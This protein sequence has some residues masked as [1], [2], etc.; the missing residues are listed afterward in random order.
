MARIVRL[1]L[2]FL[3]FLSHVTSGAS[4]LS[5]LKQRTQLLKSQKTQL[6]SQL[7]TSAIAKEH[8]Q[9][10][11]KQKL[12]TFKIRRDSFTSSLEL[13]Q[14][15]M[16]TLLQQQKQWNSQLS[17][18]ASKIPFDSL[19][20]KIKY[21]TQ[22][23]TL[24]QLEL[25]YLT[26][27]I[28]LLN[29]L[30][31]RNVEIAKI[32]KIDNLRQLRK[33]ES[34]KLHDEIKNLRQ[35]NQ[36][37]LQQ[38][39][40]EDN[41]LNP[42][43][44]S[45]FLNQANQII[46]NI[47]LSLNSLEIELLQLNIKLN[48]S[49]YLRL[50]SDALIT[51]DQL[52]VRLQ[53]MKL[54]IDSANKIFT[55]ILV[56]KKNISDYLVSKK[57][58]EHVEIKQ[59]ALLKQVLN[60]QQKQIKMLTKQFK[61]LEHDVNNHLIEY[62]EERERLLKSRKGLLKD[63]LSQ[64]K[65]LITEF[66]KL[67][68]AGSVYVYGI[69]A[70]VK[71]FIKAL[72]S[73]EQLTTFLVFTFM[74]GVWFIIKRQLNMIIVKAHEIDAQHRVLSVLRGILSRNWNGLCLIL[75]LF[76]VF[77]AAKIP[78]ASYQL[79]FVIFAVWFVFRI[80]INITRL[81]LLET[82]S[83]VAGL[84]VR[85]YHRLKLTF[86]VGGIITVGT[87]ISH[88]LHMHYLVTEFFD[89]LFMIFL[90][91]VSIVLLRGHSVLLTLLH[92]Y[93]KPNK[94]YTKRA[95]DLFTILVPLSLLVNGALGI[96][97]YVQFA[98]SMS[99]YQAIIVIV[100]ISYVVL[101]GILLDAL[102]FISKTMI[103]KLNNGWL[104]NEALLKP[105]HKILL[106]L[107]MIFLA[108]VV[109]RLYGLDSNTSVVNF[110]LDVWQ[111]NIFNVSR[112]SITTKSLVE[113]FILVALLIWLSKW[114]R[115]FCY[116][117]LFNNVIDPG[118][119]NSLSIFSQYAMMAIG[120]IITLTVLGIDISGISM[121]LGG[122]AVGMGF[123]LRDFANNIVGGLVMLIERP[124]KEGDLISV[125]NI[126]GRVIHIG[127]RSM[128]IRSWDNYEVVLPNADTFIK[129][130]TNWT[131]KDSVVRTV[132]A[133]KVNRHDSPL[134]VQQLI[135]D[136]LKIM[137]E[138]LDNPSSQVFLKH[139]D[140]ALIELEVRYYINVEQHSRV[141]VRSNVLFA[142]MAQFKAAGIKAPIPPIQIS[143]DEN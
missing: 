141:E 22:L 124:V 76:I 99:Y 32:K 66:A 136:V 121:I 132:V 78:P 52:I 36:L 129:P 42:S 21:I 102:E 79:V 62:A 63:S 8:D 29:T 44:I 72:S 135:L 23:I 93:L 96:I 11:I 128:I 5:I 125:A 40:D 10:E 122:L 127:L 120:A 103:S 118:L 33:N 84:D 26:R 4:S 112:I 140:D 31:D 65:K 88:Y 86:I 19:K 15:E 25:Q 47:S 138:V 114:S 59:K 119:R 81:A 97:G 38:Q 90:F 75:L 70:R 107:T 64:G 30:I 7:N 16:Q 116:R 87:V 68:Q 9:N 89:R 100:V 17:S 92:S 71:D 24:K 133:I 55:T 50:R 139:I 126:E 69:Y 80:T 110:L 143:T 131:H 48:Y 134:K 94:F 18:T 113:F 73:I 77:N 39:L 83:D 1:F 85:L 56:E 12:K 108:M 34:L 13:S 91:T 41:N 51:L 20:S 106:Y 2:L 53:N 105:L 58:T 14:I 130:F 37:I 61:L 60:K 101:R 57:I 49:D 27:N 54:R 95:L 115:E 111:Y 104:W 3:L 117:W 67:P 74:I 109:F 98:W 45:P 82:L 46:Y 43:V 6:E 142:I 35:Q 28:E 137:P 123:G